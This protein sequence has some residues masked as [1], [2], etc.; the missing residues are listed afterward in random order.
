MSERGATM[1]SDQDI[2]EALQSLLRESR[3]N[4]QFSS[5]GAV[6]HQLESKLGF[7]LTHK[8]DFI[9]NQIQFLYGS[10]LPHTSNPHFVLN[11]NPVVPQPAPSQLPPTFALHHQT[12]EIKFQLN[13]PSA[14]TKAEA[15]TNSVATSTSTAESA[16]P[17]ESPKERKRKGGPGGL[18]KLCGVSPELQTIVG[19][20]V[21]PRTEIVKQ[22][23]A[24]IKKHN[25]QDPSNKR[26]IIC[27]DELRLVFETDCTDMFKM[28]KLLS[29]HIITLEPTKADGQS[30]KKVKVDVESQK[31][32]TESGPVVM[33]SELLA[34]FF[35]ISEREMPQSEIIRRVWEYIKVNQ[36]ED[37]QNSMVIVCDAKLQQLFGC[38][39]FSALGI[40]EMLAS[41]HLFKRS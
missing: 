9:R 11:Q 5:L 36:L 33:I 4:F 17:L 34:N 6:V 14:V 13:Q 7:D 30:S 2:A 35:G 3:P 25:L 37:P 18:N 22:L 41:H 24:Y 15:F 12:D 31:Q 39:R 38:T 8:V 20:P 16:V 26:K 27:N 23:W 28:N 40:P 10:H 1:V 32:S 21:L 19:Q 29:K